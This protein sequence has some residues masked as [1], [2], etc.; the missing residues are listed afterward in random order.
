M[1]T[2]W[3]IVAF[4]LILPW[5]R[6]FWTLPVYFPNLQVGVPLNW[7]EA[8]PYQGKP[9][10]P[11]ASAAI[12]ELS[13]YHPGEL[14]QRKAFQDFLE[15]REE[16]EDIVRELKGLPKEAQPEG[17]PSAEAWTIVWQ[18]EKM[19][20][21]EEARMIQV[22]QGE[23]WL[24]EILSPEP[25][26]ER[27]SYGATGLKEM[28]DPES[29]RLRYLLWRREMA[30]HL[31][32]NWA[33]FLLGR[34]SRAIFASL[35]GWPGWNLINSVR[36]RLPGVRS[37]PAWRELTGEGKGPDLQGFEQHL[38][39]CLAAAG[40]FEA[41][42]RQAEAFSE[43]LEKVVLTAWPGEPDW[44][45][46]MEIWAHEGEEKTDWGPVLCWLGAGADILPG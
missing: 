8:M 44:Y 24:A 42:T 36:V 26:D 27:Q 20:A 15:S 1:K 11:E 18:M 25:W 23:K 37:E 43:Y 12:N 5:R 35:M 13:H 3:Q 31:R 2:N 21:H 39:A 9:L 33:P 22:D 38:A 4:P 7:P 17:L 29:A 16:V 41:L 19:Q 34:T 45:F 32:G 10:P 28:V 46:E 40:N 14:L 30:P 6:E